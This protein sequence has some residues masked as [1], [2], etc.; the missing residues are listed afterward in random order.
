MNKIVCHGFQL[1][2][3]ISNTKQSQKRIIVIKLHMSLHSVEMIMQIIL[4][5]VD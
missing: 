5:I 1:Q 3:D 2:F 4:K